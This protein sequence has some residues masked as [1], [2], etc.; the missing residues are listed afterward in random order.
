MKD[1]RM[2]APGVTA[3]PGYREWQCFRRRWFG[4][5]CAECTA[6]ERC[7]SRAWLRFTARAPELAQ[8]KQSFFL[9]RTRGG[10]F[11]GRRSPQPGRRYKPGK[12][13]TGWRRKDEWRS[14]SKRSE[15]AKG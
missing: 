15:E 13:Y 12:R 4:D 14:Y 6:F 7:S 3:A 5:F 10:S 8:R 1:K 9:H 11:A 2:H